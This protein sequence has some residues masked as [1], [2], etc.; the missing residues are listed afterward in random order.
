MLTTSA[1]LGTPG[2]LVYKRPRP[3]TTGVLGGPGRDVP[4]PRPNFDI[5]REYG[6]IIRA[7]GIQDN[8]NNLTALSKAT[9]SEEASWIATS[10]ADKEAREA[11][12]AQHGVI[13]FTT[14]MVDP[15]TVLADMATF[16]STKALKMGR[17]SS[18]IAGGSSAVAVSA[19]ADY[20]GKD[21]RSAGL[22][23]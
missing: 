9:S 18:A 16:G 15:M 21:P 11:V 17:L 5:K 7:H 6:D 20:A 3:R 8:D 2:R 19:M 4:A 22:R 1:A 14:G 10:I 13:A 12:L 23:Y